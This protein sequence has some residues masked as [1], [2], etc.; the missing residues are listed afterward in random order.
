[1][2]CEERKR[3]AIAEKAARVGGKVALRSYRQGIDVKTKSG[4]T[5]FVTAADQAT[6]E[7]VMEVIAEAFPDE[8]VVG[9]EEGAAK[10]VPDTG[11]AWIIDPID[12]TN[13][14]VRNIP[15]WATSIAA[16]VDGE[17]VAACNYLP[18]LDDLY[19]AGEDTTTLNGTPVSV[20]DRSDPEASAV[21]PTVWWDFE[22]RD[23]FAA[24]TRAI[25]ERF[26]DLR[27]FGSVQVCLSMVAEGALEGVLSNLYPNPWDTIAGAHLLRQAGGT[28]TDIHGERWRH[29][30]EG[31]V[32][33]NGAI[34][35][36]VLEATQAITADPMV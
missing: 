13:N 32:A 15:L 27:R 12:G 20:N 28:V 21:V 10:S 33:S 25:V 16:V 36:S 19:A 11:R 22:S 8:L 9:E 2:D 24:A 23:E 29:D 3:V 17:P 7:R 1:M 34:H 31:I 6:Q 4:K 18:V 5:D 30:S 14:Y 26:G 35:D